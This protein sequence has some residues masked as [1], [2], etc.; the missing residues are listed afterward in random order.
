MIQNIEPIVFENAYRNRAP[1]DG[2]QIL[3]Y[4]GRSVCLREGAGPRFPDFDALCN[5]FQAEGRA[6]PPLRYLFSA[7]G[8]AYYLADLGEMTLPGCSYRKLFDLLAEERGEAA[9]AAVTGWHLHEWYRTNRFCG[10]CGG[11]LLHDGKERMLA[12]AACGNMVY[13]R[14]SPGV[15]VALHS[16]SK[17]LMTRYRGRAYKRYALIAGFSEIG[18][19]IE[20]TVRREVFEEVG[21]RV[22]NLRYYK[23]QPWGMDG[24]LLMGFFAEAE[25]P[26]AE[27]VMDEEELSAA[28]WVEAAE[29]K[30]EAEPISL[31]GEM[32]QAFRAQQLREG[33]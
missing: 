33:N 18:E 26:G 24:A 27:I 16:G 10:A 21:L 28:E 1:Q 22:K 11:P 17:L 19:E 2:D 29:I 14:I 13:P 7:D 31:T 23:S 32:I 20:A 8:R 25:E 6:I 9:L 30:Y 4:Q 5:A 12:C 3:A 15:I